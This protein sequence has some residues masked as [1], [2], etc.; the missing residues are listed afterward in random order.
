M[1]AVRARAATS[2]MTASTL[3]TS[4]SVV[5]RPSV[6]R[7]APRVSRSLT[8]WA[9]RTWLA[10]SEAEEQAKTIRAAA[11]AEARKFLWTDFIEYYQTA[12][13]DALGAARTRCTDN[14]L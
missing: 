10:S 6:K 4:A 5:V 13:C 12:Y 8:P 3:S 2:P 14:K 9:S 11:A 7:T 1:P